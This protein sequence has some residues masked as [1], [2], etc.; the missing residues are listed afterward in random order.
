MV[1]RELTDSI[2]S[3]S[4]FIR[5]LTLCHLQ[6]IGF[7]NNQIR[8]RCYNSGQHK[9]AEAYVQMLLLKLSHLHAVK[10]D[11]NLNKN[12]KGERPSSIIIGDQAYSYRHLVLC[13]PTSRTRLCSRDSYGTLTASTRKVF[14]L[15]KYLP[16]RYLLMI[17]MVL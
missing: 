7:K 3:I 17:Q 12:F 2:H 14:S 1:N 15:V 9:P 5:E 8:N 13:L 16:R 10:S 6:F 11:E 4:F